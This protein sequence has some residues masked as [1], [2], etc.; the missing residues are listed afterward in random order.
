MTIASV[1]T[2]PAVTLLV[3]IIFV[4]CSAEE[5]VDPYAAVRA[6]QAKLAPLD[7]E[8]T[9]AV[10][11]VHD[12]YHITP[13]FFELGRRIPHAALLDFDEIEAQFAAKKRLVYAERNALAAKI[14]GFWL[15]TLRH[16]P[17]AGT[18]IQ[19]G[20]VP[21]LEHLVDVDAHHDTPNNAINITLTFSD[22]AYLANNTL[23]REDHV[24]FE[25][26]TPNATLGNVSGVAWKEGKAPTGH[27]FF[28]A[29]VVRSCDEIEG[30]AVG[31]D[32]V[33]DIVKVFAN[34]LFRNPV[35]F[36]DTPE[37]D[38]AL[39]HET[40]RASSKPRGFAPPTLPQEPEEQLTP[41]GA[42]GGAGP[43]TDE[44]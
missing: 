42:E 21:I 2:T 13:A 15:R 33:H 1:R 7:V 22:N 16:H 20:D 14:P 6:A 26:G 3:V 38:Y 41:Q 23:W 9:A 36:I 11:E 12:R 31:H 18:W 19:P 43:L 5:D 44:V 10:Q 24:Q 4:L 32:E 35:A 28:D 17:S 8:R 34:D 27:S 25:D 39:H 40:V 29:F 37:T 30:S